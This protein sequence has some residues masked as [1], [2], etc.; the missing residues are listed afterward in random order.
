[1]TKQDISCLTLMI[2]FYS[3]N[4]SPILIDSYRY[5]YPYS[6]TFSFSCSHPT[7]RLDHTYISSSLISKI[8]HSS[9]CNIPFSDV[10]KAPL[11]KIPS[12][13]NCKSSHWKLNNFICIIPLIHLYIQSFIK[14]LC[15]PFNPIQQ[16]LKW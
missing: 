9:Y 3:K 12:K 2:K 13:I 5:L 4:Y 8:T 1:M 14:N 6:K 7:S 15:K 11:L 10:N 16:P